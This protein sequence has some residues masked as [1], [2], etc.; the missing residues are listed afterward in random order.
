M[1]ILI[2]CLLLISSYSY[3]QLLSGVA[4]T[5]KKPRPPVVQPQFSFWAA[6]DEDDATP[7][8]NPYVTS[9]GQ[10][11]TVTQSA[12]NLFIQ[13]NELKKLGASGY[14][15]NILTSSSATARSTGYCLSFRF[16]YTVGGVIGGFLQSGVAAHYFQVSS[17]KMLTSDRF[18]LADINYVLTP[19]VYYTGFI[20]VRP[21]GVMWVLNDGNDFYMNYISSKYTYATLNEHLDLASTSSVDWM[22]G[23][24]LTSAETDFDLATFS[25]S[26]ATDGMTFTHSNSW[27]VYSLPTK[28][29]TTSEIQFRKVDANNYLKLTVTTANVAKLIEVIAGVETQKGSDFSIAQGDE[30][31]IFCN[32]NDVR[33]FGN[34]TTALL[35]QTTTSLAGTDG[36]VVTQGG[37]NISTFKV[38]PF[39]ISD[40]NLIPQLLEMQ[41]TSEPVNDIVEREIF[42]SASATSGTGTEGN[43]YTW[44]QALGDA[45]PGTT[46]TLQA[47]TYSNI[48]GTIN[49]FGTADYPV[50]IKPEDGATVVLDFVNDFFVNGSD[51]VFDGSSGHFELMTDQWSGDRF[52]TS[53]T[54]DLG[55]FGSR[56]KFINCII[57]DFG[58]GGVWSSSIASEFYGN[59][60][61]NMGRGNGS[62]GHPIYT[63]NATGTKLFENNIIVQT[64]ESSFVFHLYGSAS[65]TLRGYDI[66][67]NMFYGG[68]ILAGSGGATVE[69]IDFKY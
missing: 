64:Y 40:D 66:N 21:A 15:T 58:N 13:G 32:G 45:T 27:I 62:L 10:E 25:N 39:S 16:Q 8:T 26:D 4:G 42:V 33:I 35:L 44:A 55:V 5:V 11:M 20:I 53:Q 24:T 17:N 69:D 12:S 60:I 31:R 9:S 23:A 28:A 38:F 59:L 34:T 63:Q 61:Y 56:V 37:G 30:Y 6:F 3:G 54:W 68:R 2:V 36:Q 29:T 57:H 22:R 49:A 47:G 46:I 19:G 67:H 43:P 65:S 18:S 1:R 41:G 14:G 7:I 51:V 48:T 52:V 50:T